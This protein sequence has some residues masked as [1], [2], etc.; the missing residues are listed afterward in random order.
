M[1]LSEWS[2]CPSCKMC[3]IYSEFKKVI[4]SEQLCPMCETHVPPMQIK[5]S[6][7]PQLEFKTLI[8]LMKD[9]TDSKKDEEGD[10][11]LDSDEEDLLN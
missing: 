3:A 6:E 5:I 4:E 9:P 1:I 2:S 10:G 7:D 8:N 11:E